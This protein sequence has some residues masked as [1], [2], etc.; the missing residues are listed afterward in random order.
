MSWIDMGVRCET[1]KFEGSQ[2]F[3]IRLIKGQKKFEILES[4]YPYSVLFC[5]TE[6][7]K[8]LMEM[9]E[10]EDPVVL[11]EELYMYIGRNTGYVNWLIRDSYPDS[12]DKVHY[13]IPTKNY[14]IEFI[15]SLVPPDI[16]YPFY[17]KM[18]EIDEEKVIEG[19]ELTDM[20]WEY[21]KEDYI[22]FVDDEFLEK[23]DISKG[24]FIGDLIYKEGK[25]R[26]LLDQGIRKNEEGKYYIGEQFVV[27]FEGG[28]EAVRFADEGR[29]LLL[30]LIF[31]DIKK[32]KFKNRFFLKVE[33][34]EFVRWLEK[35]RGKKFEEEVNHYCFLSDMLV[36]DVVSKCKPTIEKLKR[37]NSEISNRD[38]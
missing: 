4:G 19:L 17:K 5:A 29:R 13:I 24:L 27:K 34:S 26:I 3:F 37:N 6:N 31:W 20:S 11:E 33:N 21:D 15:S 22:E 8:R 32:Y 25:L 2:G 12:N 10:T 14:V 28:I 9:L 36:V 7:R 18:I 1:I 30:W 23:M 35:E 16:I 38:N